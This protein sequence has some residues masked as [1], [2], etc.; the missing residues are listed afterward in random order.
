MKNVKTGVSIKYVCKKRGHG[1]TVFVPQHIYDE[2]K[3][4]KK[5]VVEE[6]GK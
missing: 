1:C 6:V 5:K 4:V 2:R 3:G